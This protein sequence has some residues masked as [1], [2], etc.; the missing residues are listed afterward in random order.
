V[1]EKFVR[2]AVLVDVQQNWFDGAHAAPPLPVW[3]SIWNSR[4]SPYWSQSRLPHMQSL[5]SSQK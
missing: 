2:D 5:S 4:H 3:F 1:L